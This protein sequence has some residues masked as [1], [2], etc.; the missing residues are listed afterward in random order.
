MR[1]LL[2]SCL[3]VSAL[4]ACDPGSQALF[5]TANIASYVQTDKTLVDHG[6]SYAKAEDCSTLTW[7]EG[8]GYC[9]ADEEASEDIAMEPAA[10][11]PFCYRSIGAIVCY[12]EPDPNADADLLVTLPGPPSF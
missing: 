6:V 3:L 7:A 10:A 4:A 5:L 8:E 9:Q 12:S 11:G 1:R 2:A